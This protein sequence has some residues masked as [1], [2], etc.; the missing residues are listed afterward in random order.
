MTRRVYCAFAPLCARGLILLATLIP[1]VAVP[2]G[3]PVFASSTCEASSEVAHA[4][5]EWNRSDSKTPIAERRATIDALAGKY[6][7]SYQVH[8]VRIRFYRNELAREFPPVRD[9]YV[10]NAEENAKDPF[11]LTL[12]ANALVGL[13]TPHSIE[14]LQQALAIS[15]NYSW[16]ELELAGIYA[17]GKFEDKGKA[18]VALAAAVDECGGLLPASSRWAVSKVASKE[19]EAKIAKALRAR[20]AGDTDPL[21]LLDYERLWTLE[22]QMRSPQEHGE[23]RKQIAADFD[24]LEKVP[25]KPDSHWLSLLLAGV[26]QS[27][28]SQEAVK[29]MEDRLLR[30][31]TTSIDGAEIAIERWQKEHPNPK[32]Q[33]DTK[34]WDAWNQAQAKA[35]AGLAAQ[36]TDATWLK[37]YALTLAIN[38]GDISEKEALAALEADLQHQLT[39]SGA[40]SQAYA[41]AAGILL[42][43]GWAPE[44][45]LA[46]GKTAWPLAE[47]EDAERLGDDTLTDD[48]RKEFTE[49]FQTD[50]ERVL[51]P[52]LLALM[53]TGQK[54]LPES[55]RAYIE[56]P[57]PGKESALASRYLGLAR[58]ALVDG[59]QADALAYYQQALWREKAPEYFQGK[60]RDRDLDEAR[61]AFMKGGGSEKV[62]AVWSTPLVKPTELAEGRWE[63]PTKGLPSIELSDLT[64]KAFRLTQVQGKAVLINLWATWCGPCQK[65]LPKFQE[66]Y[67]KV[68]NRPDVQVLSFNVDDEIGL[69]EPFLKKE[70]FTFPVLLAG[71]Q[72]EWAA[73]PQNW[74]VDPKGKWVATQ[75]GFDAAEADWVQAMIKRLEQ[76]RASK[77][78]VGQ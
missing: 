23:L 69:V 2:T 63:Q 11:A 34:A 7:N 60:L 18:K 17:S 41:N 20:L 8:A 33:K 76:T 27:G 61:A 54:D 56:R 47:L 43:K 59:R 64:G 72:V 35:I 10:Q 26:K 67:E 78:E 68:K 48:Q 22:F 12:A 5:S 37:G 65:E 49:V 9:R 24:R 39:F 51:Q 21:L 77:A 25:V 62:F 44:K 14:L 46:W 53:K 74:V 36:F 58:L 70:G 42:E 66:L 40:S 57:L 15:P 3:G 31:A 6:P 30:E 55:M 32:D 29:A 19:I 13:L 4:I 75:M 16:A 28:A 1:F 71:R 52:Y 50:R 73:I 45:A 38:V